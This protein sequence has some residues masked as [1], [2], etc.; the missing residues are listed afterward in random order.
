MIEDRAPLYY[1]WGVD[2]NAYGPVELPSLVDWVRDGRVFGETWVWS[3]EGGLWTKAMQLT[4]LKPLFAKR[5]GVSE[6]EAK[7]GVQVTPGLLR[8]VKVLAD[9]DDRALESML[10]YMEPQEVPAFT[11][12]VREGEVPE[13]M[14]FV[15][16]GELRAY[17]MLDG[18]EST[19]ATFG[20]GETFGELGLLDHGPRSANVASNRSSLLLK[21]SAASFEQIV[22]EAPGLASPLGLALARMLAARLRAVDKRYQDAVRF[23]RMAG[24]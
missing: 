20:V 1:V 10:R 16:E 7:R 11:V 4:E 22:R 6:S 2:R 18:K 23:S 21:L 9:L 24:G 19:L 17:G 5:S 15:L 8:R 14:Y 13:A 3:E 12:V